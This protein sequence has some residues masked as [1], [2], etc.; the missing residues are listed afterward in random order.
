MNKINRVRVSKE[1]LQV[2]GIYCK[3]SINGW[4]LIDIRKTED[5]AIKLVKAYN[6]KPTV[7]SNLE[8]LEI[9]PL[10]MIVERR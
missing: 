9:V 1:P 4:G 8:K 7:K 5:E 6:K 2:W 3:Y 10:K